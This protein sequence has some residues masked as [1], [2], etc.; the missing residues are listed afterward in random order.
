MEPLPESAPKRP[1]GRPPKIDPVTGERVN[2]PGTRS[3]GSRK[4]RS[5]ETQIGGLLTTVNVVVMMV[6]PIREDALDVAEIT[7]L[8]KAMDAQA[9]QSPRF[10]KYVEAML[11][12]G[13]GGQLFGVM[14]IIAARR[15][16]RHGLA[17]AEIDP[18]LGAM[19]AGNTEAIGTMY[20][21]PEAP[22]EPDAT[23]GES[24]PRPFSFDDMP[25]T[26][27]GTHG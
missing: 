15:A 16:A 8:A 24:A 7:A 9:Q 4:P 3:S 27:N 17:P 18:M 10:R 11:A 23:T 21:E 2:K 20:R 1:R 19:L 26:R 5:L 14:A 25:D 13:S 6:P 22:T 12:A